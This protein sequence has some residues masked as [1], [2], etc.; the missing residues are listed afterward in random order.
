M[1]G[2]FLT[3]C[4]WTTC[5]TEPAGWSCEKRSCDLRTHTSLP[6]T[7]FIGWFDCRTSGNLQADSSS[8][9]DKPSMQETKA[10]KCA[11]KQLTPFGATHTQRH[12]TSPLAVHWE[13]VQEVHHT[14][15]VTVSQ[16]EEGLDR[17]TY[18]LWFF[19]AAQQTLAA[20]FVL[21]RPTRLTCCW[22][23]DPSEESQCNHFLC[24]SVLMWQSEKGQW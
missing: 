16:S 7:V 15:P 18:T 3:S 23:S 1:C 14:L 10:L 6:L 24:L 5:C 11:V 22:W 9:S 4:Q 13:H 12:D 8:Y 21:V 19:L 17:S 20:L 2:W